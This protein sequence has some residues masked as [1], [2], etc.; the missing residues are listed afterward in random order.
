MKTVYVNGSL[1]V[2]LLRQV[3]NLII[4][5]RVLGEESLQYV[6]CDNGNAVYSYFFSW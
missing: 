2:L 1:G 5:G 3:E 6:L 4:D